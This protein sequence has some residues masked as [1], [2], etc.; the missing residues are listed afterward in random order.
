MADEQLEWT[1]TLANDSV[2]EESKG[3]T[4]DLGWEV[5]GTVK[6]IELSSADGK[7]YSCDLETGKFNLDGDIKVLGATVK[8]KSLFFR[9]RRQV[10]SDGIKILDPPRTKYIFG[11]TAGNNEYSATVQPVLGLAKS[12]LEQAKRKTKS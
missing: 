12:K 10:R 11:F 1:I 4:F 6:K 5:P 8:N 7:V 3:D 9:K 2:K